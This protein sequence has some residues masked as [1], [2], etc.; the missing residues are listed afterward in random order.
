MTRLPASGN[1][2]DD[3]FTYALLRPCWARRDSATKADRTPG[4]EGLMITVDDRP[5]DCPFMYQ[6]RPQKLD[7]GRRFGAIV[8]RRGRAQPRTIVSASD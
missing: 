3:A 6:K 2:E 4:S 8:E 7:Y 5:V 1:D